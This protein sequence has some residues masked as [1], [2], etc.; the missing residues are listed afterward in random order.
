MVLH[1]A[2]IEFSLSCLSRM[3]EEAREFGFCFMHVIVVAWDD[4]A[5][6]EIRRISCILVQDWSGTNLIVRNGM[7]EKI[8]AGCG[9]R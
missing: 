5:R 8:W 4:I 6:S 1:T 9:K 3:K 7:L 2:G